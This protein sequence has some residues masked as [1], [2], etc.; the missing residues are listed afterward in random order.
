MCSNYET[1]EKIVGG[2]FLTKCSSICGTFR[3]DIIV[4]CYQYRFTLHVA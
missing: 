1:N 2:I 3:T 4:V